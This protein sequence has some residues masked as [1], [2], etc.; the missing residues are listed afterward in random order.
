MKSDCATKTGRP[1]HNRCK[2]MPCGLLAGVLLWRLAAGPMRAAGISSEQADT[3]STHS[4]RPTTP[5]RASGN[6]QPHAIRTS[7]CSGPR[8]PQSQFCSASSRSRPPR[9][10]G[11]AANAS[12]FSQTS[13]QLVCA[14]QPYGDCLPIRW[15]RFAQAKGVKCFISGC[16]SLSEFRCDSSSLPATDAIRLHLHP[17]PCMGIYPCAVP[18]SP[19]SDQGQSSLRFADRIVAPVDRQ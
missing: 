12:M 1:L 11:V 18:E 6:A 16:H 5:H 14:R 7:Y 9:R 10:P 15:R 4:R 17:F 2:F 8:K 13:G 3:S 19:T